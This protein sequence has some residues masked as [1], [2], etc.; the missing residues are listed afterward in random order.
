MQS[1]WDESSAGAHRRTKPRYIKNLATMNEN[2][3][4]KHKIV[5]EVHEGFKAANLAILAEY[6]GV[7]V[8]GM[9]A[10]RKHARDS[11]VHVRVVKNTLAKRAVEDT[12]F[13]CLIE[14]FT[15]PVAIATAEDP[16]GAAKTISDFAK[17]NPEFKVQTGAMNGDLVSPE[18]LAA[19]AKLPSRDELLAKLLSTMKAPMQNLVGTLNAIPVNFVR[20]LAA[21]RD[22]KAD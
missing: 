20:T 6:R 16:V 10:L 12:E 18:Q 17:A 1:S 4:R 11:N 3:E 22:A 13:E 15:G 14:H 7:D 8:A 21:V 9:S 5:D 19:L 2:L